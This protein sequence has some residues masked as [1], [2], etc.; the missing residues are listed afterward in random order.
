M[1]SE[2]VLDESDPFYANIFHAPMLSTPTTTILRLNDPT[3][4]TTCDNNYSAIQVTVG[5]DTGVEFC[6]Y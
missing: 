3:T 2:C 4:T 1:M 6:F 5:G